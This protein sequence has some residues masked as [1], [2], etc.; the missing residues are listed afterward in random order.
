MVKIIKVDGLYLVTIDK[1][2]D[3]EWDSYTEAFL[4]LKLIAQI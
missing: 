1:R 4:R 3:S 2:V